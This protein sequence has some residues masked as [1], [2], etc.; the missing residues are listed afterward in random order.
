[1]GAL[2]PQVSF[3]GAM[4]SGQSGAALLPRVR[5]IVEKRGGSVRRDGGVWADCWYPAGEPHRCN[6]AAEA[7]ALAAR[8][9]GFVVRIRP[10]LLP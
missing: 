6:E 2:R 1:M 3:H 5:F 10:V 8:S 9:A 7:E 4:R